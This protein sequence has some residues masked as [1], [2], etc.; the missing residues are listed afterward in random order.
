MRVRTAKGA[1][2]LA[3]AMSDGTV[4][5]HMVPHVIVPGWPAIPYN[6]DT[7]PTVQDEPRRSIDVEQWMREHSTDE[8]RAR[9]AKRVAKFHREATTPS[10]LRADK[11]IGQYV[12]DDAVISAKIY[13][14]YVVEHQSVGYLEIVSPTRARISA[15]QW[16]QVERAN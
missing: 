13:G 14:G 11:L 2:V 12:G 3:H 16:A 5:G 10:K 7:M 1:G 15:E 6:P 4:R 9:N 8:T